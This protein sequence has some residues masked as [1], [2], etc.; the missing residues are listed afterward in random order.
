MFPEDFDGIVA[1]CPALDFN[2]LQSWRASFYTYTGPPSSPD[3]IPMTTWKTL[4]HNEV[5]K[6]CDAIDGAADGIIEDS[7]LCDFHSEA[8]LCD[9]L[10]STDCL[11]AAQVETVRKIF[12]PLSDE[13]GNLIY[14][15][16]Q[17]GSEIMAADKLYAGVPFPYSQVLTSTTNASPFPLANPRTPGMVQIRRLQPDLHNRKLHPPRRRRRLCPQPLQYPHLPLHPRP[18]PEHRR[19]NHPLPRRPGQSDYEL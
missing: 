5:L 6:Q 10:D 19:E 7:T 15:A 16:M 4:I 12:S 18:L 11:T 17:P 13:D 1:G 14:P 3:F 9:D 8:L 2:N